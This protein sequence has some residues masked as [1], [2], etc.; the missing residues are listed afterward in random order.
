M[1]PDYL[2]LHICKELRLSNLIGFRI[3]HTSGTELH[4]SEHKGLSCSQCA[5]KLALLIS[6]W[7]NKLLG[8]TRQLAI[9]SWHSGV[10]LIAQTVIQN[11]AQ[12]LTSGNK[13]GKS[14]VREKPD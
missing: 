6:I 1:E 4:M 7:K 3:L 2:Y 5:I 8:A 14:G 13:Q 11:T 9:Y 10:A 12:L